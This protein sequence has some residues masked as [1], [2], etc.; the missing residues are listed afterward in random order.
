MAQEVKEGGNK[1]AFKVEY[2]AVRYDNL[3][4]VIKIIFVLLTVVGIGLAVA[5]MFSISIEGKTLSNTGYYYLLFAL[6]GSAIFLIL[7]LRKKG[8]TKLPWYDIL[9]AVIAFAI[10][11][12]FFTNSFKIQQV[13]WI[14]AP[15][16]F[17][18]TL[19]LVH[20]FIMLEAARR[21]GGIIFFSLCIVLWMYPLYASHMPGIFYGITRAITV[22]GPGGAMIKIFDC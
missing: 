2:E 14:P 1:E 22:A 3:P 6:F 13:G 17:I 20:C 8:K 11:M 18:F 7:P 16:N 4:L 9:I 21:M 15:S 10:P 5:F 19:A 12:Y